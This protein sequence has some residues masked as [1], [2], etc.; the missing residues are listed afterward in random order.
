MLE[1]N[2]GYTKIRHELTT[3]HHTH[4]FLKQLTTIHRNNVKSRKLAPPII[5]PSFPLPQSA[6]PPRL[7]INKFQQ[8]FI[9]T[10]K[11]STHQQKKMHTMRL[12]VQR[13]WQIQPTIILLI[14]HGVLQLQKRD[15]IAN[16]D[17]IDLEYFNF[18]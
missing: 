1:S 2:G 10:C 16:I 18:T 6:H 4:M 5:S 13:D 11:I 7:C 8:V 3:G 12:I 17:L 14:C 15:A 9:S